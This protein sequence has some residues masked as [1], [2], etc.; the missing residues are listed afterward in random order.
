ME[1]TGKLVFVYKLLNMPLNIHEFDKLM[2]LHIVTSINISFCILIL[3][4][5]T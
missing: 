4:L 2:I 1:T 5:W 3:V